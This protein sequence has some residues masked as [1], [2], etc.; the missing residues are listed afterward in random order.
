[1]SSSGIVLP[2]FDSKSLIISLSVIILFLVLAGVSVAILSMSNVP[3]FSSNATC[4]RQ[5]SSSSTARSASFDVTSVESLNFADASDNR[6][7]PSSCLAVIGML[8]LSPCTDP[9]IFR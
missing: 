8:L 2:T 6:T 5:K 3:V 4:L 9:L 1:M 7:S